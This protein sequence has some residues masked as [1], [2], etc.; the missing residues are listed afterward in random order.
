MAVTRRGVRSF[1]Q[2]TYLPTPTS[3]QCSQ[4]RQDVLAR[5]ARQARVGEG[6]EDPGVPHAEDVAGVR[7]GDEAWG[8]L[9]ANLQLNG[10]GS[11]FRG[12]SYPPTF[13]PL[14]QNISTFLGWFLRIAARDT[15]I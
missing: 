13:L 6:R 8:S 11:S 5:D 12:A 10:G 1:F 3:F 4:P 2:A 15:I 7:L 9:L 14:R